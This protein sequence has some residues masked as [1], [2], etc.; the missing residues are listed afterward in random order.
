L[1]D[2]PTSGNGHPI[3]EVAFDY[4]KSQY[5]RVIHADG[6][7][8]GPTPQGSLH[9]AFYAERP[10]LPRRVVHKV[11]PEGML[12]DQIPERTVTRDA[13]IREMDVDVVMRLEVAEQFHTWLGQRL[14]EMKQ[15]MP[16]AHS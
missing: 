10:P 12:G 14:Q 13:L 4:I 9:F 7:M 11:T 15:Q 3:P 2:K 16:G 6:V 5:F 8:G 1:A